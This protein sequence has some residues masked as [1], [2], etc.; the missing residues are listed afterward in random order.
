M[1]TERFEF[2]FETLL[3]HAHI[4][5]T[6]RHSPCNT[7]GYCIQNQWFFC[8]DT[9]CSREHV[10]NQEVRLTQ[11]AGNPKEEHGSQHAST[12]IT[13]VNIHSSEWILQLQ[14]WRRLDVMPRPRFLAAHRTARVRMLSC[15]ATNLFVR[16]LT[17][18]QSSLATLFQL[19][20]CL[21]LLYLCLI[22]RSTCC[23]RTYMFGI[24]S[25]CS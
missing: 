5:A 24:Q 8:Y 16:E 9:V 11:G 22:S 4:R 15:P 6:Q 3:P 19:L 13:E 23:S 17:R 14:K 18:A 1:K 10:R 2:E 21:V 25:H 20:W 12:L 7:N